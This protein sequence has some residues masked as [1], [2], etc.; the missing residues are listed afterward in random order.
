MARI[1]STVSGAQVDFKNI[2]SIETST[3]SP[4]SEEPR[5]LDSDEQRIYR[6]FCC[7]ELLLQ[8]RFDE[9]FSHLDSEIRQLTE[10]MES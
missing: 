8:E 5:G 3:L 1:A 7:Q 2:S 6:R 4:M 9:V 10:I